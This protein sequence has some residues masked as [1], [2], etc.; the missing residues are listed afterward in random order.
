MKKIEKQAAKGTQEELKRFAETGDTSSLDSPDYC[1]RH[2]E[3]EKGTATPHL[4]V[5]TC[6][7]GDKLLATL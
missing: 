7:L 5:T 6:F 4:H 2:P 3:T 1:K